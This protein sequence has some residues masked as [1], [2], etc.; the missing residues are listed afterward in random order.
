[1]KRAM[2]ALA[3]VALLGAA[4]AASAGATSPERTAAFTV[5][6][7]GSDPCTGFD[8]V[9]SGELTVRATTYFDGQ[10]N[11]T[12]VQVYAS[13]DQTLTNSVSG[14]S[15]DLRG[16]VVVVVDLTTGW[17][18]WLGQVL[19]SNERGVGRVLQDTGRIV[20][21]SAGNLAFIAGPHDGITNPDSFCAALA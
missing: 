3:A 19:M 11:P 20:F 16:H 13:R 9:S 17:E 4:L 6:L 21:D 5:P 7:S 15:I 12:R 10:G 14:K 8:L 1:M 18:A 2:L